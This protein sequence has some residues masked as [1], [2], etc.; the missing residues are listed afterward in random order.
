MWEWNDFMGINIQPIKND[1][2]KNIFRYESKGVK[3]NIKDDCDDLDYTN[4]QEFSD[5][6][7][8]VMIRGLEEVA[9]GIDKALTATG[10]VVVRS[11]ATVGYA[12]LSLVEGLAKFGGALVD[13]ATIL[14]TAAVTPITLLG[15]V[16][17]MTVGMVTGEEFDSL[18]KKMWEEEKNF[19]KKEYVKDAFDKTYDNTPLG[20]L[21]DNAYASEAVR[22]VGNGLGEAAGIVALSA[23]TFGAGGIIAGAGSTGSSVA[24]TVGVKGGAAIMAGVSGMSEGAGKAWNNDAGVVQG[25]ATGLLTG[26]LKGGQYYLG[27]KINDFTPFAQTGAAQA[28]NIIT[29]IGLD[30]LDSGAEAL[31]APAIDSVYNGKG[32][33]ESFETAGGLA[34]VGN[35]MIMGALG[36][37]LGEALGV[38]SSLRGASDNVAPSIDADNYV[39]SKLK[40]YKTQTM[41]D[42]EELDRFFTNVDDHKQHYGVDQ[43][44]LEKLYKF[45]NQYFS[46]NG[47][48]VT[49]HRK[50]AEPEY[51]RL[52]SKLE[53][54]GFSANQA[55]QII[56]GL[57][58]TGACSYASIANGFM[59]QFKDN[60]DEFEKIFGFNMYT[61]NM[62]GERILNSGELLLDM[63][64]YFND[65]KNGGKLFVTNSDG[66]KTLLSLSDNFELLGRFRNLDASNQEYMSTS[67]G[68]KRDVI[69]KYIRSKNSKLKFNS[70]E[71][72]NYGTNV[73]TDKLRQIV[74]Q[75]NEQLSHGSGMDMGIYQDSNYALRM[76]SLDN[77]FYSITTHDWHEGDGHAVFVTKVANDGFVVSSWGRRFLI[78]F[79]D[80]LRTSFWHVDAFKI[81]GR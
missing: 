3:P 28:A 79:E 12:G 18:T 68:M 25:L 30:S 74:I 59:A 24:T 6:H 65:K 49:R 73:T 44:Y 71:I 66:T 41:T 21:R 57:N 14:A 56:A 51:F 36:S 40:R 8:D 47:L 10:A 46:E 34:N 76:I 20:V 43:G 81:E 80:L 4:Y 16:G 11:A 55:S 1:F 33:L 15:D 13:T 23:L 63:Y 67:F 77:P 48:I 72:K 70:M 58:S 60:P 45:N 54:Q 5:K 22:S 62:D 27:G 26:T 38:A 52:K 19:V 53:S 2:T 37:A 39:Y 7:S 17:A 35:E 32:Y 50:L 75:V 69:N 64:T 31:I 42:Y 29:R 9:R 78:P 61:T